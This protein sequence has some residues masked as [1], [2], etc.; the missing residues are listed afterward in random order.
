M[1]NI[2]LFKPQELQSAAGVLEANTSYV[3][4]YTKKHYAILEKIERIGVKLSPELDKEANDFIAS[5][6]KCIKAMEEARKPFTSKLQEV[7]KLYTAKENEL[8]ALI[9]PLQVAR[10]ASVKAYAEEEAELRKKEQA[11]LDKKREAIEL[12]ASAEEQIR[13]GYVSHLTE[14]KNELLYAL[15]NADS[16]TIDGV[17]TLLTPPLL[18]NYKEE[19]FNGILI[20]LQAKHHTVEEVCEIKVKAIEGKYEKVLPHYQNEIRAYAE[21]LLS[22]VPERRLEIEAGEASKAAEELR[23]K[24]EKEAAEAKEIADKAAERAMEKQIA[25]ALVD[26]QLNQAN[27]SVVAPKPVKVDSYSIEV[28]RRDGW[29]QIFKFFFTH[30]P[31]QELGKF[32]MD[33]MKA[34]AEKKAKEGLF[35]D[36][37]AIRYEE[38]FKTKA[39]KK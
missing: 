16:D 35:I 23:V 15:E 28:T 7:V 18:A 4:K 38:Q 30:S 2:V 14:D 8:K 29:A 13:R 34:F 10:N 37:S 17:E 24:Q 9:G 19:R 6:N 12:L 26:T 27:R 25:E 32:K 22:L 36:S 20:T 33:Q 5:A 3:A 39:I 21:H 31:E 1:S 11:D